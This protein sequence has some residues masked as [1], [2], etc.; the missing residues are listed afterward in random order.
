MARSTR[1]LYKRGRVWWMTYFDALGKQRFESCRTSNQKEA[2]GRLTE[3]RRE[4]MEGILPAPAIK[5]LGLEELATRYLAFVEHQ[6]GVATK[7]YH[8]AHFKRV[9]GNPPIH[10]LTVEVLDQYR[11]QRLSEQVGPATINREM[12]TLK[13]ALSKAV[14]WKLLRKMSREELTAIKKYQEPDGRLRYL[15]GESEAERLLQSCEGW[16]KPIVLTAIHTGMRKGELLGLTWDCVDMTHGFI[17]LKQ[18]KNGKARALPLNET[19]WGVFSGLRTRADVPWVFH[20]PAGHR[21]ED[22]RHPFDR[23]CEAAGL[24]DFHFHDLRHTFASWLIMRGV[25]LATVS[26]LLGHTSPTMT[27]RYAHLSPKHLTSAVRV[28]DP[29]SERSHDSYMTIRHETT[30]EPVLNG[31]MAGSDETVNRID[32]SED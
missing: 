21:W 1:G 30:Q 6:R 19:L 28:L 5:P 10:S 24:T 14:E 12:A 20:D 32:R 31:A 26:N 29:D 16:L 15:S 22:V 2:G 9:W 27:L 23:A 25:P 4:V 11:A 17:R 8:F 3:R 7:K 18:T 13:H